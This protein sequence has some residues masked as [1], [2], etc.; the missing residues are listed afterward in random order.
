MDDLQTSINTFLSDPATLWI[1]ATLNVVST[2][3][4][5]IDLAR[6]NPQT[7]GLM[8]WVWLLTALYSGP[9]GLAVYYYSGRRQIA[10]DSLWRRSFRSVAHCYS[11]CGA[12]EIIGLLLAV[13][14]LALGNLGVSL[15]TFTFAYV[16]GFG[17]TVGPLMADGVP[18]RTA[19]RDSF[20]AETASITVMEVTAIGIDLWLS[21]GAG[22]SEP[23]FW[24]S[25]IFSLSAGFFAAYP[26]NVWLIHAGV[27]SGMGHP[28]EAHHHGHG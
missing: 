21:A 9:I 6:F 20:V 3:V 24:T 11:G 13:G 16:L 14:V 19:V 4:V 1:W 10:R 22:P 2:L 28:G 23:L 26:V 18:F 8:R 12:G 7:H 5:W 27:K 15:M 25:M 17:L